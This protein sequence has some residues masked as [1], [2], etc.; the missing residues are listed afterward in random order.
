MEKTKQLEKTN[1]RIPSTDWKKVSDDLS[2][3]PEGDI[4]EIVKGEYKGEQLFTYDS[5]IRETKKASKIIPNEDELEML[6]KRDEYFKTIPLVGYRIS[7]DGMLDNQGM[8]GHYWTSTITPTYAYSL[9]FDS[10]AVYPASTYNRV[11]GF[12]VRCFK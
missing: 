4:W 1:F 11:N 12:S 7:T 5:A 9:Y 2:V 8:Y 6:L 10:S 3:N